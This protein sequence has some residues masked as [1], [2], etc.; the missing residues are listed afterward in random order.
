[1]QA[2]NYKSNW[3][4]LAFG[5]FASGLAVSTLANPTGLTVASGSASAQQTGSQ[6][7]ITAGNNAVLNWQSFN[8][9]AGEKTIFN[10]PSAT[11]IVWNRVN[12]PNPSQIFGSLQANGV[13]VLLN[14][15][16]FYFGPNSFVSAAGLVVSTANY[17]PPQNTGGAWEFNGPPPLASIVNYGTIKIGNGGSAFL[18][19]DQVEN[20][21]NIEAPGGSIGLAAGQSVLLSERPDGRGMSMSVVLPQGSVNNYGHLTADAGTI[22]LNAKVVNQSGFIEA[23][24]VRNQNGVIE[25]VA[26]DS[27]NLGASSEIVANGDSSAGGSAGGQVTLRSGNRFNDV[28]G[29]EISVAGGAN[30][31]DGGAVEIS[32]PVMPSLN[33]KI[34]GHAQ[35]GS[36]GG[37]LLLDPDYIVLDISGSDSVNNGG[38]VSAGD[39]PGGTLD[40]NVNSAFTGLSQITLQ[41]KYDIMLADGTSWSLSDSTGQASGLLTLEAGRNIIF[42]NTTALYDLNNWSIALFAGVT[43]FTHQTVTPGAGSIY[44]N[45][46]DP[47]NPNNVVTDP[48]GYIKT[49][50]GS[51]TLVA[52]QDIIVGTGYVNTTGGGSITAHALAGNID[53]GGYAQGYIFQAGDSASAGYLVDPGQ[54]VGGIS[55]TAGG[56]ISLTAGGNVQSLLPGKDG[57]FYGGN[58]TS[59]AA[60]PNITTAGTGAYGSQAGNVTIVAGGNVTGNYLVANGTGKIFAGVMMD[61]NGNPVTDATGNY[62]LGGSGSAGT[63]PLN[64]N[65]ALN[66]INGGWNVAAAQNIILQEVRNPNGDFNVNPGGAFH[67]FDYAPSDYV[68]LTAGDLVQLG[69][70]SS[71]LPRLN[72]IDSLKV[73]VIYPGS[74]NIVAGAGGVVLDGDSTYNQLILFPSPQG[75]LTISTTD[76]GSLTGNLPAIN[77]TPQIFNLIVSDSGRSQYT[78]N[79]GGYFGLNDHA[80]APVHLNS[81]T[82]LELNISGDMNLVML[83]APEAA[84]INVVGNMNNCSFQGMNLNATDVTSIMVGQAAKINLENSCILN[85]ATDGGLAVGGNIVNRSAFTSIDL[86]TVSG[87]SVPDLSL[88]SLAVNDTVNGNSISAAT[89]ATSFYYNPASHVLTYQ[90]IKGVSLASLIQLLQNLTVQKVDGNGNPLWSDFPYDTIPA[91]MTVSVLNPATAQALLAQYN[92]LGAIPSGASGYTIGGGGKFEISAANM[93]LGTTPG[94]QSKGVGL[95]R[96]GSLYPLADPTSADFIQGADILV[97]L[98]GDLAMYSSSIASLNG[99]NIYVNADGNINVGSS[100]F[101]VNT[102]G[103]R[104]IYTTG[105]GNVAV[106]AGNNIDVNGSRVAAYDIR[107]ATDSATLT[108]GGSVTVVSRNGGIDAGNGG[109]GFVVVN[110]Y[111]VNPATHQVTSLSP[112]IPGSGILETSYTQPGN[113]LVE[114]PNG[115]INAGAGGI[116]QL[117]LNNPV[118]AGTTLFGLPLNKSALATIFR[119]ALNGNSTAALDFQ[120][121]LNGIS[122]NSAVD[123]YAGYELQPKNGST[124]VDSYGNPT[125]SAVNLSD[126]TLV[127]ISDSQNIDATGSGVIAA[128]SVDLQASGGITGNVFAL[129][130]VNINA[131]NNVNISVLGLGNVNVSSGAGSVSGTIIGVGGVS[132]SGASIDAN[133]ESNGSVS[134]NTSGGKGLAAGTAADATAS[135]AAASDNSAKVAQTSNDTGDDDPLKKKKKGITLARKVSRVT[136]LLPGPK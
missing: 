135:A 96:V 50:A 86:S 31:G 83:G 99:G 40:L 100:D 46:F 33:T 88:L 130:N 105:Q 126:G 95:Y 85:P 44:L 56:D 78:Q 4:H 61:A 94:I 74:L 133:L 24:S 64:P 5:F 132:A 26:S 2:S 59:A 23:N 113:V 73:P 120:R 30:G 118:P 65:L 122:G 76:G 29:S 136:V 72:G 97:N 69:A 17:A 60:D 14:S 108:P 48:S 124:L 116:V 19:A 128:G 110:A 129:G 35:A 91:S 114:A 15:S 107:P 18:I 41:A 103:A 104:G 109:S 16:G 70:S 8:I 121:S 63:D 134:G 112:T 92:M 22:A 10:Q 66:L 12:D 43:D 89:L 37:K 84:Q 11:S 39:N 54:G 7:N 67:T 13:V 9:A 52:G 1:M 25:L 53:T 32:A 127:K 51:I 42:G 117:L 21:G 28:S 131:V 45:A 106:Y 47:N 71:A 79:A 77:G 20:H 87:A 68:N 57:Y 123:V 119:L 90:N 6:L 101:T 102:L 93:D 38:T 3:G 115:T 36:V 80:A 75:G 98:T 125:V 82:P 27:L 81:E 49:A 111:V 62:V 55:T 58:F 34:D